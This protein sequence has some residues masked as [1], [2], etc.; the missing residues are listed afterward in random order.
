MS[1][2]DDEYEK[3]YP[4]INQFELDEMFITLNTPVYVVESEGYND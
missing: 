2:L 1:F 3:T 4:E